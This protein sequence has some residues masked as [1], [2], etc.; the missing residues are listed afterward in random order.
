MR[1]YKYLEKQTKVWGYPVME[2][3][4]V[5]LFWITLVFLV[6]LVQSFYPISGTWYL[7]STGM[8]IAL[9]VYLKKAAGKDHPSFTVS[10]ISYL[11]MQKKYIKVNN[12]KIPYGKVKEKRS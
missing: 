3:V 8:V 10:E 6:A 7:I 12:P 2:F 9:A 1:A 4:G 5:I 11:L